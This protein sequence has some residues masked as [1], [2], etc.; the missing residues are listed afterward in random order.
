[1]GGMLSKSLKNVGSCIRNSKFFL[2]ASRVRGALAEVDRLDL[3]FASLK[4]ENHSKGNVLLSFINDPFFLKPGQSPSI[5]HHHDWE[6]LQMAKT[7]LELGY[8]VDVINYNNTRFVPTKEYAILIDARWNLER[9]GPLLN[10]DCL[11]IMH[12]DTAHWVFH[13]TALLRRHLEFQQRKKV[14][15][16]LRRLQHPNLAIQYADC[17]TM[18]GNEFTLGTFSFADKPIYPIPTA[19]PVLY[20]WP[21]RKDFEQCRKRFLWFGSGGLIHKGLDLVLDAFTDM[22][23]YHLTVCGP[24]AEEKDFVQV[25]QKELYET[26]NIDTIGW[27]DVGSAKFAEIT[28]RCAGLIYPSCSEGRAGS[29]VIAMHAGLIPIVS[30]E[31][32]VDVDDFGYTLEDCSIEKI[33]ERICMVAE[34][35]AAELKGRAK[36]AW[37]S[38]RAT[39]TK[40]K[41]AEE[42]RRG[43]SK[44]IAAHRN[45]TIKSSKAPKTVSCEIERGV[46]PLDVEYKETQ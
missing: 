34:L 22:P 12:I 29:V 13:N 33:K 4:P 24:I 27:V 15:P 28:N 21:E 32:G 36:R 9:L 20:P 35:P 25:Y 16:H 44:F 1:M 26:G 46:F 6:S 43:I 37:E 45:N 7:L 30:Y 17:A 40:E 42:Y 41:F 5:A 18:K 14:T 11:K 39:H 2:M 10:K 31:S 38:A 23:Q 19:A 8:C 3:R